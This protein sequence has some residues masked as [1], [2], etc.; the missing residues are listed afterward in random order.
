LFFVDSTATVGLFFRDDF[1]FVLANE[2]VR[3]DMLASVQTHT[4]NPAIS[5]QS[6][7]WDT[8]LHASIVAR[9]QDVYCVGVVSMYRIQHLANAAC[10]AQI[11]VALASN[12]ITGTS[13]VS[14]AKVVARFPV[15]G[16][17]AR[18]ALEFA[19]AVSCT[20]TD[21]LARPL[22]DEA[23]TFCTCTCLTRMIARIERWPLSWRSV[24][25][26]FPMLWS[27]HAFDRTDRPG[28]STFFLG[29]GPLWQALR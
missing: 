1:A 9:L 19:R 12:L 14:P 7:L 20:H 29:S 17:T 5:K 18:A 16:K 27:L 15:L 4:V 13:V 10:T 23:R 22:I 26:I 21:L 24:F 3:F 25:G 28:G 2:L 11:R 6:V 8:F